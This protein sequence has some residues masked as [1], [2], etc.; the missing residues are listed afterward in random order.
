MGKKSRR[1]RV[2]KVKEFKT[3]VERETEINQIKMKLMSLGFPTEMEEMLTLF[4]HLEMYQKT[5]ESW[6][7]KIPFPGFQRE[8]F[9]TLTNRKHNTNSVCLK[10]RKDI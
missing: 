1:N 7:G 2:K 8:C 4:E 9:V 5:G 3:E 6:S 10:Y